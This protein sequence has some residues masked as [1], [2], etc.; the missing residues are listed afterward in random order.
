VAP[1]P[2][3]L[4]LKTA[5]GKFLG[6]TEDLSKGETS[7]VVKPRALARKRRLV[8]TTEDRVKKSQESSLLINPEPASAVSLRVGNA[9]RI[10]LAAA[11]GIR[12][13]PQRNSEAGKSADDSIGGYSLRRRARIRYDEE[14]E[15]E[16]ELKDDEPES[17]EKDV[18][19][20]SD[21]KDAAGTDDED[22][23]FSLGEAE[24]GED[25]VFE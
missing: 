12:A 20:G 14:D 16:I 10:C 9:K 15:D 7:G 19:N 11:R 23:E 25:D 3:G 4:A 13:T 24:I 17:G 18:Q 1:L 21:K 22:W 6:K 8:L 2:S 5:T